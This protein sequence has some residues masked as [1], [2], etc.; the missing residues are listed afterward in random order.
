[1]NTRNPTKMTKN[2]FPALPQWHQKSHPNLTATDKDISVTI[3]GVL[4]DEGRIAS[5]RAAFLFSMASVLQAYNFYI[6]LRKV[7]DIGINGAV[8]QADYL[9]SPFL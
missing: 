9:F 5:E 4:Y 3:T 1:M 7:T 6:L 2:Q 8:H